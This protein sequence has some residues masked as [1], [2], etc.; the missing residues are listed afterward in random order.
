MTEF[1]EQQAL[2]FIK[3]KIS[4]NNITWEELIARR[5]DNTVSK[6]RQ[7]LCYVLHEIYQLSY[8][9]IGKLLQRDHAAVL[10]NA[11]KFQDGLTSTYSGYTD[12]KAL[13]GDRQDT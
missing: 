11:R 1:E 9:N 13:A 8:P 7:E 5:K 6:I 3:K 4:D 12:A 10:K 2:A